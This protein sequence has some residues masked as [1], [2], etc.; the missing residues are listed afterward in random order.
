MKI[1]YVFELRHCYNFDDKM[2]Q[3]YIFRNAGYDVEVWSMVNWTFKNC[4]QPKNISTEKF[5]YYINNEDELKHELNRISNERVYF[6]CYPFDESYSDISYT[7]RKNIKKMGFHYSNII[8]TQTL[9]NKLFHVGMFGHFIEYVKLIVKKSIYPLYSSCKA[10]IVRKYRANY[11]KI[12]KNY[13][14]KIFGPIKYESD[15][16]FIPSQASR[17]YI[18]GFFENISKRCILLNSEAVDESL[19]MINEPRYCSEKYVV[20]IDQFITGHSDLKKIG[21]TIVSNTSDYFSHLNLLFK[22]IEKRYS[23]KIIIA[24]HPKAEYRGDEFEGR[25]IVYNKTNLL[26]RDCEFAILQFSTS[27]NLITFLNKPFLNIYDKQFFSNSRIFKAYCNI[28]K[29]FKCEQLDIS[30]LD[31]IAKFESYVYP[32][33]E[34]TYSLHN[35]EYVFSKKII[36]KNKLF[37]ELILDKLKEKALI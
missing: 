21:L 17:F 1:I 29:L 23:Y 26:I 3:F 11:S 19:Q 5:V 32:Y 7:I 20:F 31:S 4:P 24:A 27:L 16:N 9:T 2:F 30:D 6:L 33:T 34:K 37:Y 15:Y 35:E 13:F 22:E 36:D 25:S 28:K 8:M 14:S 18:P 12:I 10:I